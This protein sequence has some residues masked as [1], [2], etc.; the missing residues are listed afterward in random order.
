MTRD[1]ANAISEAVLER[2][3]IAAALENFLE[4]GPLEDED[5]IEPIC[6]YAAI[7]DAIVSLLD[8]HTFDAAE[9]TSTVANYEA[10]ARLIDQQ[11]RETV[12]GLRR[13]MRDRIDTI[14]MAISDAPSVV[15]AL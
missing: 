10:V 11:V 5:E 9:T 3:V 13:A 8:E 1:E 14:D 12:D 2:E 6:P 4:P 15:V 7:S